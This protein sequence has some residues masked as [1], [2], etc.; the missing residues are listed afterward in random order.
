MKLYFPEAF[1]KDIG[2]VGYNHAITLMRKAMPEHLTNDY[3]EA[4]FR[5]YFNLPYFP[6]PEKLKKEG[7]PIL[8]YT[9]YEASVLPSGWVKFLNNHVKVALVPSEYSREV[10]RNSGVKIPIHILPLCCDSSE[11]PYAPKVNDCTEPYIYLWQGV[12]F[13]RGGRKGVEKVVE[14]FR[15]LK[16]EKRIRDDSVLILKYLPHRGKRIIT[17]NVQSGDGIIYMQKIMDKSEMDKL[18]R[19]VDCCVNP[20]HGE[21]FGLIPLEQMARCKPVLV[22]EYS[23]SFVN[24][25]GHCIPLKYVLKPSPVTWNHKH[26]TVGLNAI[27]TNIGGL[28][29]TRRFM[30]KMISTKP[31]NGVML[32]AK[33]GFEKAKMSFVRDKLAM[34]NN[35]VGKI[36]KLTGLYYNSRRKMWCLYSEFQGF[37]AHVKMENLKDSMEWCHNHRPQAELMGY[38]AYHEVVTN[39]TLEKMNREFKNLI[40][41]LEKV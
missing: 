24:D 13:D 25:G 41:E 16:K 30:P 8:A 5:V 37:D 12:A 31:R 9:M 6:K 10:F 1:G 4:R 39:W 19:Q 26:I 27:E 17:D 14:A 23:M 11:T 7:L 29:T 35:L 32:T 22:T 2:H 40:P 18:Y 38:R 34:L 21:G 36:Q 33:N 15:E 20:T 3:T 28:V